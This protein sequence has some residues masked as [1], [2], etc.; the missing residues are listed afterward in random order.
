M[1]TLVTTM[2]RLF[3][4]A[5]FISFINNYFEKNRKKVL[6]SLSAYLISGLSRELRY[7]FLA[8]G[9]FWPVPQNQTWPG[10]SFPR[11]SL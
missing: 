7:M 9:V 11:A 5:Y 6:Q 3:F 1:Y 2:I 10:L 8:T 4:R